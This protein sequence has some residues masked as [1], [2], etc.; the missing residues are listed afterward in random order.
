MEERW[1]IYFKDLVSGPY[2]TQIIEDGLKSK[3][4]NSESLIW[5]KGQKEW[6]SILEWQS[7]LSHILESFKSPVQKSIW[8]VEHLGMQKGPM[9]STELQV[10]IF[11]SGILS[12]CRVWTVG[13]DSWMNV[14]EVPDLAEFFGI[15]RRRFPRAPIKGQVVIKKQDLIIEGPA[16]SISSGGLGFRDIT[17]LDAG[18][19]I[20]LTLKSPLLIA[21]IHS[22]G[23]VVYTADRGFTGLEFKL[24]QAES[25]STIL[26]YVKRFQT[27][28]KIP[29]PE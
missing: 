9:N 14:F 21:P 22:Q 13:M 27:N 12:S 16:G 11:A 8:Y 17:G 18:D 4:W 6:I 19:E 23:K 28:S 24:L 20:S 25:E 7:A 15:S 10:Y 26:D 3:K 5:W 2:S 1:F 29:K